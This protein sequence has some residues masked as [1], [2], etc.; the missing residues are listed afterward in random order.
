MNNLFKG[1]ADFIFVMNVISIILI[2]CTILLIN[3]LANQMNEESSVVKL[4]AKGKI[5]TDQ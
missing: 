5:S 4:D 3:K 2:A 1:T